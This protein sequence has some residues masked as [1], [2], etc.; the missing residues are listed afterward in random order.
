MENETKLIDSLDDES[1]KIRDILSKSPGWVVESG[2]LILFLF[3]AMLVLLSFLIKY[4]LIIDGKIVITSEHPSARIVSLSDGY[5]EEIFVDDKT[6]TKKGEPLLLFRN[7]AKSD[8][9]KLLYDIVQNLNADQLLLGNINFTYFF[10]LGDIQKDYDQFLEV[11]DDYIDFINQKFLHA[12]LRSINEKIKNHLEII[13]KRKELYKIGKEQVEHSQ[14]DFNRDSLLFDK[15]VIS[16]RDIDVK[17]I[18]H[19]EREKQLIQTELEIFIE[20]L[21]INDLTF[22]SSRLLNE[23]DSRDSKLKIKLLNSFNGLKRALNEW[24]NEYLVVAPS[25]G[26]VSFLSILNKDKFVTKGTE[27]LSINSVGDT[28]IGSVSVPIKDAGRIK[29][30]QRVIIQLEDYPYYEYGSLIGEVKDI[31]LIST[32]NSYLI[33]V[34]MPNGLLSTY[35]KQIPFRYELIGRAEIV[36]EDLLVID[37]ILYNFRKILRSK[38]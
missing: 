28:L 23:I 34:R 32:N 15:K 12:Q 8:D 6:I 22:Q 11:Y 13:A 7:S 9:V 21:T 35:N 3:V 4:P 5:I 27:L 36:T 33:N 14:V 19:L 2:T 18:D 29:T 38:E 1:E 30:N 31:S 17:L 26:K 24:R 10:E 16:S 25:D 37:R 20:S